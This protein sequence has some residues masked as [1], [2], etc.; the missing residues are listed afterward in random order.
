MIV[1]Y[2]E[3]T[4]GFPKRDFRSTPALR[5]DLGKFGE[6]HSAFNPK[7]YGTASRKHLINALVPC[8]SSLS[9]ELKTQY[10]AAVDA[11]EKE[12]IESKQMMQVNEATKRM[13]HT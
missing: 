5:K 1:Q 4:K 8:Y 10:K 11:A 6:G 7:T 2:F 3:G 9:D 13:K 12:L